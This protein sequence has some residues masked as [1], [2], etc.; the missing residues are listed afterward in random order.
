[1]KLS[2]FHKA[3]VVK[4]IEEVW[5][6]CYQAATK[7]GNE[8][9]AVE[10]ARLWR[11]ADGLVMVWCEGDKAYAEALKNAWM[12]SQGSFEHYTTKFTRDWLVYNSCTWLDDEDRMAIEKRL[13]LYDED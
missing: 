11:V 13:E 7:E 6:D 3:L 8:Y 12:D 2:G 10:Y 9:D 4:W 1:V 5:E